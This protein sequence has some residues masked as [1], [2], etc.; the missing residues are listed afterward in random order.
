MRNLVNR[1]LGRVSGLSPEKKVQFLSEQTYDTFR[2]LVLELES[3]TARITALEADQGIGTGT[4]YAVDEQ[5]RTIKVE[6]KSG[7]VRTISITT[8]S[9]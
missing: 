9:V 1:D 7:T 5:A 3:L 4:I 8:N 6:I 2:Q